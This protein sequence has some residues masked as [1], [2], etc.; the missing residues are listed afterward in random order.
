MTEKLLM[1]IPEAQESLSLSRTKI[2]ELLAAKKLNA[3][4]VG[5]RRLIVLSSVHEFV[6]DMKK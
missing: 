4:K 3:V 1:T 5:R 2:Y 6:E